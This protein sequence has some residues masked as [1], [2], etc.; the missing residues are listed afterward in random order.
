M[1]NEIEYDSFK[2]DFAKKLKASIVRTMKSKTAELWGYEDYARG[3]EFFYQTQSKY[4]CDKL[5]TPTRQG[6]EQWLKGVSMPRKFGILLI[7]SEF[8]EH[9]T[10]Q[11]IDFDYWFF[12]TKTQ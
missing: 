4:K 8:E 11:E 1:M 7:I 3:L 12:P 5:R 2:K 9:T 10:G 6:L